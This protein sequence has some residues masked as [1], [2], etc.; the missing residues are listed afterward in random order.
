[1]PGKEINKQAF[2]YG[3]YFPLIQNEN[4]SLSEHLLAMEY[5]SRSARF[6]PYVDNI[7]GMNWELPSGQIIKIGERVVKS[8]TG[9]DL[10][11]FLLH[12]NGCYG[13]ATDYVIRLR[14]VNGSPHGGN[15]IG[16]KDTL[17]KVY[18]EL[19]SSSW[20][21]WVD[22]VDLLFSDNNDPRIEVIVNCQEK[23]KIRFFAYFN[24]LSE[25]AGCTFKEAEIEEYNPLPWMTMKSLPSKVFNVAENLVQRAGG[26]YRILLMNGVI[27]M[28]PSDEK[29]AQEVISEIKSQVELEGGHLY[30]TGLAEIEHEIS[31]DEEIWIQKLESI[32]ENL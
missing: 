18:S 32:W 28:D 17:Q 12:T 14:P 15:F 30:G 16:K 29:L 2:E 6:G 13:H 10:F 8:T 3:L 21:H 19:R 31:G 25:K 22:K 20:S 5:T 7:L 26:N 23:E 24:K 1:M 9:Y 27:L 11:R 4:K